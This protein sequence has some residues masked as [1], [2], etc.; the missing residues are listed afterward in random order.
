MVIDIFL[1]SILCADFNRL[2]TKRFV[3]KRS[4]CWYC[5]VLTKMFVVFYQSPLR[6]KRRCMRH[7][8]PMAFPIDLSSSTFAE[9][10]FLKCCFT[11]NN[12]SAASSSSATAAD[13]PT[14]GEGDVRSII[15]CLFVSVFSNLVVS[16]KS[17]EI[18]K[19]SA[20]PGEVSKSAKKKFVKLRE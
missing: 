2:G 15:S 16:I 18:S 9:V 6:A 8:T 20:A 10:N 1:K 19:Q 5:V 14:D 12:Y 13:K 7:M 11:F 17:N 3:P 4:K